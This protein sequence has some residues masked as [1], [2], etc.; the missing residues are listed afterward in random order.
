MNPVFLSAQRLPRDLAITPENSPPYQ[1]LH[2]FCQIIIIDSCKHFS[3]S[4]LF[5]FEIPIKPTEVG[6]SG[7][8]GEQQFVHFSSSYTL[9][10]V[11]TLNTLY[12]IHTGEKGKLS[13]PKGE[14]KSSAPQREKGKGGGTLF[15]DRIPPGNQTA[16]L[17]ARTTRHE[18]TFP[19]HSPPNLRSIN[20]LQGSL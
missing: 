16:R 8:G 11:Y 7:N 15:C 14:R 2:I 9:H 1:S 5:D 20:F 19:L 18:S 12:I 17:H 13:A 4:V 3:D 10:I 6:S